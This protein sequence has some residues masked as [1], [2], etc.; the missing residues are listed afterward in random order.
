M[1]AGIQFLPDLPHHR[2]L[3]LLTG[4]LLSSRKLPLSFHGAV[5]PLCS[6][7]PVSVKDHGCRD[8]ESFHPSSTLCRS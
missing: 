4:L 3:R 8:M 7:D 2:F 5:T 6:K 1:D